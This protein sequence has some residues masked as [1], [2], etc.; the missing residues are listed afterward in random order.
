MIILAHGSLIE[1]D[2]MCIQ[3]NMYS[4]GLKHIWRKINDLSLLNDTV[5]TAD[6]FLMRWIF[7]DI[8]ISICCSLELN[9]ES[10]GYAILRRLRSA[11][12]WRKPS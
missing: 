12:S 5:Q 2:V 10:V 9:D 11:I 8:V 1:H 6:K 3:D 4:S 7:P